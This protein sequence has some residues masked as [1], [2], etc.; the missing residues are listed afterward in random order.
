MNER[1]VHVIYC[2]DV[3]HEEGNKLTYVGCYQG[4]MFLSPIPGALPKFCAVVYV[5][6]P[7]KKPF[8]KL[9]IRLLV[10]SEVLVEL[11]VPSEQLVVDQGSEPEDG[12]EPFSCLL[13]TSPSP[14]D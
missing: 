2:D 3:R 12:G 11:I 5:V 7:Y 1:F 14:R 8:Q 9:E 10:D 4:E 6:T 13:Y